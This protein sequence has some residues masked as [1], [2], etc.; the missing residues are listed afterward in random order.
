MWGIINLWI[1]NSVRNLDLWQYNIT[2]LYF[3]VFLF[4]LLLFIFM[5]VCVCVWGEKEKKKKRLQQGQYCVLFFVCFMWSKVIKYINNPFLH[6]LQDW[7][8]LTLSSVVYGHHVDF[9]GILLLPF[10]HQSSIYFN[11]KKPSII[12]SI[13]L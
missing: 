5:C 1:S 12:P 3:R 11:D 6:R 4:L 13:I 9:T 8:L 10:W 2:L 7:T